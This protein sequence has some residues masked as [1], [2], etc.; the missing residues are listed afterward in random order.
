[1]KLISFECRE[2]LLLTPHEIAQQ[3]LDLTRWPEFQGY[4]PKPGIRTAEFEI[5]SPGIVGTRIR[6][7]N[8]D[9]SNHVEEIFEWEPDSR[10]RLRMH[11]FS[12]PLSRLATEF[13]EKWEFQPV[14]SETKII[15]SFELHPRSFVAWPLL[16]G[17]SLLLRRAIARHL[18]QMN[19]E[20]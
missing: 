6:V 12:A 19:N 8:T 1:M 11:D 5:Q 20:S 14:G 9:G 16:W 15:R 17:I 7:T 2:T 3:I 4:G 18:R 13:I 10:L